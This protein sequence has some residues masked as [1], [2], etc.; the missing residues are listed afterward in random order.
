[1]QCIFCQLPE[2]QFDYLSQQIKE[3]KFANDV[4]EII[5]SNCVQ[6]IFSL[7]KERLQEFQEL[8][9]RKEKAKAVDYIQKILSSEKEKID[10]PG[11]R[12]HRSRFPKRKKSA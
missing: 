5:C 7:S 10:E 8:N 9:R 6:K 1:M 3:A 2:F 4:T 12:S 11:K